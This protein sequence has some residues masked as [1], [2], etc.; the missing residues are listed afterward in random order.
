[1]ETTTKKTV[2]EERTE[3]Q[4]KYSHIKG[5]GIDADPEN[6][7]TYPI[8]DYTGDDH[9][10]LN[11]KKPKQQPEDIEVLHSNERP[12]VSSVFGTSTP[13]SGLSGL[14]RRLAFRY[15]E[16]SFGHWLPLIFADRVNIWEGFLHDF[17]RLKFPNI[18]RERGLKAEL[19]YNKK[20]FLA[21][22]AVTVLVTTFVFAWMVTSAGRKKKKERQKGKK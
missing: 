4:E 3:E 16:S 20:Q 9:K 12:S 2:T 22:T 7:P 10:R 17:K 14:I 15:S 5:W 18:F 13:P 21:K 1:M 8:K 19:K 11:Y 6:E